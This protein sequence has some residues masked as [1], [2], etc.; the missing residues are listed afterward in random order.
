M[1]PFGGLVA[2]L[3]GAI[4]VI[5]GDTVRVDGISYRLLRKR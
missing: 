5:D 4:V 2:A 3:F 1:T